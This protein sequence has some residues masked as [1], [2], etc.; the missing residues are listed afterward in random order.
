MP[1]PTLKGCKLLIVENNAMN[2]QLVMFQLEDEGCSFVGPAATVAKAL[3]LCDSESPDLAM[4]DYRLHGETVEPVGARLEAAN[5]P[6]VIVT[7]AL[8][9]DF[10][11]RFPRAKS[12]LKPFTAQQLI[13]VLKAALA[14]KP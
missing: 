14:G 4:L 5:I 6:Y 12:L 10:A 7:G 2:A 3:A 1:T 9:Q 8:P 11:R 13:E